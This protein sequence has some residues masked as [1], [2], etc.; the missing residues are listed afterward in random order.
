MAQEW[1]AEGGERRRKI[2]GTAKGQT[3]MWRKEERGNHVPG[4]INHDGYAD[5]NTKDHPNGQ[6][7]PP[8]KG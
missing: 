5:A 1:T 2:N 3:K 6:V 7:A 8:S 4:S